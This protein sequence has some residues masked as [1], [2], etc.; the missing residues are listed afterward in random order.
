M[1]NKKHFETCI[2]VEI[3]INTINHKKN[4]EERKEKLETINEA[5]QK[6]SKMINKLCFSRT[7]T[8]IMENLKSSLFF[9]L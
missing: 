2:S 4:Y 6:K 5:I 3:Q 8:K 9:D 1:W 7:Y